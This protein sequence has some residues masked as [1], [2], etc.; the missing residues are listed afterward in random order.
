S[1]GVNDIR[2]AIDHGC[3]SVEAVG[4]A[5]AAGT[6]CGSCRPEIRRILDAQPLLAAE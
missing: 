5:L 4:D 3:R 2:R 6:N 1:V